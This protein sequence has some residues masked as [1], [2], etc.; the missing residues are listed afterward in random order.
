MIRELIHLGKLNSVN[1]YAEIEVDIKLLNEKKIYKS[2]K[3]VIDTGAAR[4]CVQQRVIADDVKLSEYKEK[5]SHGANGQ[6]KSFEIPNVSI[7]LNPL[8]NDK[9]GCDLEFV[10]AINSPTMPYDVIIGNDVLLQ[11]E[12]MYNG[13]SETYLLKIFYKE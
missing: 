11:A 4:S 2:L 10:S 7:R 12:F 13:L 9:M 3:A 8:F 6:F 1:K 5:D